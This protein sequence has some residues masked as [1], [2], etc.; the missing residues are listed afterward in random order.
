[1]ETV[2][3]L[4]RATTK[5]GFGGSQLGSTSPARSRR[6]I[7][8]A[9][10]AGVR[11]FDVAPMYGFGRSE[12]LLREALG[13]RIHDIT[14][15]TKYGLEPPPNSSW[16]APLH[17]LARA[18]LSSLPALRNRMRLRLAANGP[19]ASPLTAAAALASLKKSLEL[20]G[21]DHVDLFLLHEATPSRLLDERL[22][23]VLKEAVHQGKIANFGLGSNRNRAAAC[24]RSCPQYCPLLQYE[25]SVFCG[26]EP[27]LDQVPHL[28]HG[29]LG[30]PRQAFVQ[31]LH[32]QKKLKASWSKE[33][34]ADL[35]QPGIIDS[36]LFKTAVSRH[37]HSI[38]L[39]STRSES[40]ILRNVQVLADQSLLA[41]A[42]KL[43]RL[44]RSV[45]LPLMGAEHQ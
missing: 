35:E 5:L 33:T 16:I 21:R 18:A 12:L 3:T 17:R 38:V 29:S 6:L 43:Q 40:N 15:T 7:A 2:M 31:W 37:P 45:Y 14:V 4:G 42:Q 8:A 20:L 13:S 10:D 26:D 34:G 22:L 24:L 44:I 39:F 19:P 36:L 1:M 25:W 30:Q 41:P 9:F 32:P 23:E 27:L 11:H 28:N